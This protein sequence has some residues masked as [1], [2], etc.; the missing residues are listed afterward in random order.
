M[1]EKISAKGDATR[2]ANKQKR[3]NYILACAGEMIAEDGLDALTLARLAERA[4]VTVPTIHNLIGKKSDIYQTLVEES[5][6]LALETGLRLDRTDAI[7]AVE[8]LADNLL[9]LLGRNENYYKGAFI[10]GERI[11]YFGREEASGIIPRAIKI[12]RQICADAVASGDLEG[13]IDTSLLGDRWFA[14]NRLARQDWMNGYITLET[15]KRQL[16]MG[17]FVTLCADASPV[18]KERLLE[19]ID[20]LNISNASEA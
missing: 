12:S 20:A 9:G 8:T 14:A 13:R 10:A 18:F 17:M 1:A 4:G 6:E 7:K 3:R 16:M 11:K 2:T 15:Y 19:K 5:M